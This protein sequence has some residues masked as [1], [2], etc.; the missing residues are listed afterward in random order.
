[1]SSPGIDL[2]PA[3]TDD[4]PAAAALYGQ[5]APGRG[6]SRAQSTAWLDTT[7]VAVAHGDVVGLCHGNHTSATWQSFVVEPEPPV[8]WRC[9]YL[10]TLVVGSSHRGHGQ[11]CSAPGRGPGP[12]DVH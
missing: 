12:R 5:V 2:R 10:D 8:E 7:T 6:L 4:L 9:S 3:T 1:M 11:V